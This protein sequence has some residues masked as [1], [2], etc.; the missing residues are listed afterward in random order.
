MEGF[1]KCY[2]WCP[3]LVSYAFRHGF[4]A[5]CLQCSCGYGIKVTGVHCDIVDSKATMIKGIGSASSELKCSF[6]NF[7]LSLSFYPHLFWKILQETEFSSVILTAVGYLWYILDFYSIFFLKLQGN[8]FFSF[9]VLITWEPHNF[10]PFN[11]GIYITYK[12]L[13]IHQEQNETRDF[14]WNSF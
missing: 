12:H 6:F 13:F 8:W 5:R 3:Q 1:G 9:K 2:R 14:Y 4:S 10:E 7:S 11:I